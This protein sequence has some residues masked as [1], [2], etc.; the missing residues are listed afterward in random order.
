MT[1]VRIAMSAV[2]NTFDAPDSIDVQEFSEHVEHELRAFGHE[3]A[4]ANVNVD[5]TIEAG[6]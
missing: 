5:V 4:L 1:Q 2:F 6:E 3:H